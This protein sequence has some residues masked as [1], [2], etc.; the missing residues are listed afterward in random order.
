M[1]KSKTIISF[2][3]LVIF[4]VALSSC[5]SRKYAATTTDSKAARAAEAMAALKSKDL[6]RFITNW[7][8]VT[9]KLGGLEKKE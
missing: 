1:I 9:Y 3:V 4:I 6:Y 7:T 5:G 2:S 8:G